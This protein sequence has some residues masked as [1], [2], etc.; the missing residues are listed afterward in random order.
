MKIEKIELHNFKSAKKITFDFSKQLNLFVGVNGAGKSTVLDALSICL[1]WLV[2][3]IERENGRGSYISDLS[4]HNGEDEAY[5]DIQLS[6][7]KTSFRWFLTKT[8]KGKN[9]TL[10]SNLLGASD[11]AERIKESYSNMGWPV[12]AYYPVNRVVGVIRPN[13]SD[14]EFLYNLDIYENALGGKAN[15]EYLFEWF[16]LQDDIFNERFTSRSKW[17]RKNRTFLKMVL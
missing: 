5:L 9:S 16:R 11:L 2:K 1:S 10:G 15:N 13:I 17:M 14:K 4:L 12:I 3:R 6:H 7:L 8:A